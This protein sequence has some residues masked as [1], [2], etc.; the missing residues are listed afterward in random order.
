MYN[1]KIA[2]ATGVPGPIKGFFITCVWEERCA[3]KKYTN[4]VLYKRTPIMGPLVRLVLTDASGHLSVRIQ[5]KS[6]EIPRIPLTEYDKIPVL[7]LFRG[8][9]RGSSNVSYSGL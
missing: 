2:A 1:T 7:N 6:G 3:D 9:S 5:L 4:F 8:V